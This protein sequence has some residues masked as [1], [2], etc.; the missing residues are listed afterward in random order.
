MI[1]W[2]GQYAVFR[3]IGEAEEF[4]RAEWARGNLDAK[5]SM[6]CWGTGATATPVVINARSARMAG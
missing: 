5:V 6:H 2:V 3:T 1:C 4:C